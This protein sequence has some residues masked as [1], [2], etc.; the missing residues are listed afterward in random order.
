M[1]AATTT[2]GRAVMRD[3]CTVHRV[4]WGRVYVQ[5]TQTNE[6]AW[7]PEFCPKCE[8]EFARDKRREAEVKKQL[9]EIAAETDARCSAVDEGRDARIK[10][11]AG[12][13]MAEDVGR[14]VL[15][16]FH[17]KRAGYEAHAKEQHWN[18]V[19]QEVSAERREEYFERV[20]KAGG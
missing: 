8:E 13:M 18:R 14:Y 17:E 20:M 11:E 10:E 16:F 12:F 6:S 9:E 2:P 4:E 5:N 3:T 7:L 1:A 19:A 15:D